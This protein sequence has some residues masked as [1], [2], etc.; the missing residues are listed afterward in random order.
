MPPQKDPSTPVALFGALLFLASFGAFEWI[1]F[2]TFGWRIAALPA[3]AIFGTLGYVLCWVPV[4]G[5]AGTS[6]N[7]TG[8][9]YTVQL[10]PDDPDA[11]I[12]R[13]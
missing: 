8:T 13:R 2:D 10:D 5:N 12:P 1:L 6:G 11:G 7:G 4:S 9:G 3:L